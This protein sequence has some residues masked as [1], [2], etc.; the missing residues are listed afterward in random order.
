MN[1]D[2]RNKLRVRVVA[3]AEAALSRQGFVNAI[4]VLSGI[5]WLDQA[6]LKRWKQAQL[7]YLEAGSRRTSGVYRARNIV[8]A[9]PF[10]GLAVELGAPRHFGRG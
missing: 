2:N 9:P 6:T 5:G 10:G 8:N 7:A 1:P 4:D 3:A